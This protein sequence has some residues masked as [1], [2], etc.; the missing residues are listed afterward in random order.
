MRRRE[1]SSTKFSPKYRFRRNPATTASDALYWQMRRNLVEAAGGQAATASPATE[2]PRRPRRTFRQALWW[3]IRFGSWT[4]RF[5]DYL[6]RFKLTQAGKWIV[7]AWFVSGAGVVGLQLAIYQVF[8]AL[9][10]L[11]GVAWTFGH[12]FR[13]QLDVAGS[14]PE[15]LVAGERARATLAVTNPAR[16]DL[17]PFLFIGAIGACGVDIFRLM[18]SIQNFSAH[19]KDFE[20]SPSTM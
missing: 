9:A 20:C 7:A 15:K 16:R 12:L 3:Y 5:A 17:V 2:R 1:M 18:Q 8:C 13:P 6:W 19:Y 10:A 4:R 11:V 14:L